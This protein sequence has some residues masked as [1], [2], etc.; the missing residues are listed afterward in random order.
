METNRQISAKQP[1]IMQL[2]RKAGVDFDCGCKSSLAQLLEIG[3]YFP[4]C[5]VEDRLPLSRNSLHR[6]ARG[7]GGEE[8]VSCFAP[9]RAKGR[10]RAM[11]IL[12]DLARLNDLLSAQVQGRFAGRSQ[13]PVGVGHHPAASLESA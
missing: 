3:G 10:I 7:L 4:L 8:F 13:E 11:T 6:W 1:T 9:I 12:V 2:W 5:K